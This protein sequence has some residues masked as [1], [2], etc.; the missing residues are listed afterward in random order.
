MSYIIPITFFILIAF[1]VIVLT[2]RRFEEVFPVVLI[3][4]A[5]IMYIGGFINLYFSFLTLGA[6]IVFLV[7]FLIIKKRHLFAEGRK[8]LLT[9]AFFAFV[10]I[11]FFLIILNYGRNFTKWDEYSHWGPMVK[12][13]FRLNRFYCVSELPFNAHKD[14]PPM[15]SLFQFLWCKLSG[16]FLESR[17]YLSLQVLSISFL[18]PAFKGMEWE[19]RKKSVLKVFYISLL[20]VFSPLIMAVGEAKFYTTIYTD[21]VLGMQF[22]FGVLLLLNSNLKAKF[23]NYSFTVTLSML[24][25]TKQMGIAF[26]GILIASYLF[27]VIWKIKEDYVLNKG[28][29]SCSAII[30]FV[31]LL[32]MQIW[33]WYIRGLG[34]GRQFNVSDNNYGQVI[35]SILTMSGE[36]WKIDTIYNYVDRLLHK[37]LLNIPWGLSYFEVVFVFLFISIGIFLFH[38]SGSEIEKRFKV[39]S[40]LLLVG[41]FVYAILMLILYLTGFSIEESISTACYPRYM[42]TYLFG[43]IMAF[44]TYALAY[45]V[46]KQVSW[47]AFVGIGILVIGLGIFNFNLSELKLACEREYPYDWYQ[48]DMV[49]I[50]DNTEEY[51]KILWVCVGEGGN[52]LNIINYLTFPRWY[53]SVNYEIKGNE[54][55]T[56][57]NGEVVSLEE[58]LEIAHN[59]NYLY[60]QNIDENFVDATCSHFVQ[61]PQIGK[62]QLFRIDAVNEEVRFELIAE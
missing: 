23:F 2:N 35:R 49:L 43:L 4:S 34:L 31:P 51:D 59:Y 15:I 47:K 22:V 57:V 1:L 61:P 8:R 32:L 14:Y 40:V 36:Q 27:F 20:L 39:I 41:S 24:L 52:S 16:G 53:N 33:N 18:L 3:S 55:E 62:L 25:L 56:T 58:W 50:V 42:N 6:G 17:L 48:D 30:V 45:I 12:E 60:L 46:Q 26:W 7:L 44:L 13:L 28:L 10:L 29:I 9:P 5:V 21:C 54:K 37:D 38:R 11:Y 19:S